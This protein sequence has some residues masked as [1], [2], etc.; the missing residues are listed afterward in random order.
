[1]SAFSQV[2]GVDLV[3]EALMASVGLPLAPHAA[4][5]PLTCIAEYCIN[6]KVR[7]VQYLESV[8]DDVTYCHRLCT[9][10]MSHPI[11]K[12]CGTSPALPPEACM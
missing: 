4:P 6:A 5:R 7:L 2:W 11:G 1:M 9:P 10:C 3:E 8:R 12:G